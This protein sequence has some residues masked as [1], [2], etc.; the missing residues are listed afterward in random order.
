MFGN[1]GLAIALIVLAGCG[2]T[3]SDGDSGG[4]AGLVGGGGMQTNSAGQSTSSGGIA[5]GDVGGSGTTGVSAGSAGLA[6]GAA[7]GSLGGVGGSLGG[8][9]GNGGTGNSTGGGGA[10]GGPTRPP[11]ER[12]LPLPCTAPLPTGYCLTSDTGDFVGEGKSSSASGAAS[13]TLTAFSNQNTVELSLKNSINGDYFT[14]DFA[15]PANTQLT[16]GLYDLAQR[17]PFQVGTAAGLSVYGNGA[18][19]DTVTGKFSVEELA[20]DPVSGITRFSATFEQHCEGATPALRGVVNFQATGMPDPTPTPDQE[21]DLSGKIFRVA[22]DPTSNIAYGLDATNRRLAKIDL[23]SGQVTYA[24]VVQVPN[25]ACVDA[26]R[27]RLFVVNKGSSLITEYRTTDLSSVRDITW[28]GTDWGPTETQF[29]IYCSATQLYVVDGAW[30]PAL[31]TVTGLDG[32]TPAATATSVTGVGGLVLDSAAS[33]LYYWYQLGWSA[34]ST[35]TAV[36]RLLTSDLSEIDVTSSTVASFNRDPLDAPILLDE[37]RSLVFSKNKIFD[38]TNL[39]K[40]VYTL[41]SDYDVFDGAG[42]NAYA[43]DSAHGLLATNN[44]V[45]ELDRYSVVDATLDPSA[46]Q[47]F[48]DAQGELWSLSV[49]KGT[50]DAQIVAH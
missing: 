23:A 25:D 44:F 14:A 11:T 19:C 42:E 47:L 28:A 43:L 50:L 48:F 46:D 49:S 34:G 38:A 8:V 18:G 45:Y 40:L 2:K 41:P 15:A 7:G 12:R 30:A 13:V 10:G 33:N 3:A 17:Y 6:G 26:T 16:P 9:G 5:G 27:G 4:G 22:Y 20:R 32:Q 21:I 36:H 39:A 37:S 35:N 24:D 1:R 29:K 31:F